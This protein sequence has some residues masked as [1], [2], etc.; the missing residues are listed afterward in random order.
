MADRLIKMDLF[1]AESLSGKRTR[2]SY[3]LIDSPID[4]CEKIMTLADFNPN[5]V[6]LTIE[7]EE[8]QP[9]KRVIVS[10]FAEL[11]SFTKKYNISSCLFKGSYHGNP[12]DIVVDFGLKTLYI[13]AED[14]ECIE[15]IIK[16][17]LI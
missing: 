4:W 9:D 12:V 15:S 14:S 17:E 5:K 6:R 13:V 11:L 1:R 10:S 3:K 16:G 7:G 2:W 8:M